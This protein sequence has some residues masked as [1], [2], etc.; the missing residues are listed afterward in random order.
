MR[1][2]CFSEDFQEPLGAKVQLPGAIQV[3]TGAA[4]HEGTRLARVVEHVA[5]RYDRIM[6]RHIGPPPRPA[7]AHGSRD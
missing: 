7:R 5:Q 1:L 2:G 3:G 4:V 6:L